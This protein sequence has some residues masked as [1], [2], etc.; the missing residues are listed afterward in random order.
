MPQSSSHNIIAKEL[1]FIPDIHSRLKKVE[2]WCKERG[3][4]LTETRKQVL[5]LI[6]NSEKPIGAYD[7][8]SQIRPFHP[9][10]APPTIYRALDFLLEQGLVHRLER[11]SAFVAC[12][13][14]VECHH[15]CEHE[16]WGVH[17]AQF[18]ICRSCGRAWELEQEAIVPAVMYAAKRVGFKA[19][20]ATVE[21]EGICADCQKK[22]LQDV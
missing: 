16:E 8:L 12:S 2:Q 9:N 3:Q 10:A 21:V 6:L 1:T 18:L 4:R 13:H 22:R 14:A 19:E 15:G 20:A 5:G 7:L 17:R 11:L